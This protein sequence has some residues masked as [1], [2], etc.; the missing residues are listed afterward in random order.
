[1]IKET[2]L[3]THS[4]SIEKLQGYFFFYVKSKQQKCFFFLPKISKGFQP[5]P[6]FGGSK[7]ILGRS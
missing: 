5:S 2:L 4:P 7:L 1:M 3:E 6:R